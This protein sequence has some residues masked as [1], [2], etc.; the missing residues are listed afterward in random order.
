MTSRWTLGFAGEAEA[1][2]NWTHEP[3]GS[4]YCL[5]CRRE[6]AIEAALEEAGEIGAEAR[7]K[8]R[9]VALVEFEIRRDPDRTEGE[10]AKAARASIAAVRKARERLGLRRAA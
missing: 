5:I 10:I 6:R 8:L 9:T 4:Y 1:P 2:P 3:D 7:A